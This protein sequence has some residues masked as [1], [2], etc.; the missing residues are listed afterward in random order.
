MTELSISFFLNGLYFIFD[1]IAIS[2]II[3]ILKNTHFN[4]LVIYVRITHGYSGRSGE[5]GQNSLDALR[6]T[7][8]I[9]QKSF[10]IYVKMFINCAVI[11]VKNLTER[12]FVDKSAIS[13]QN[14]R[15]TL[16]ITFRRGYYDILSMVVVFF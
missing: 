10:D 2:C 15:W 12:L 1:V 8:D 6:F 3:I 14:I 4:N 13:T 5:S 9:R 11:V 16:Q 7:F